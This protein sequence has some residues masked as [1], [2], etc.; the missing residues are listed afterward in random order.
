MSIPPCVAAALR[1]L[2][3]GWSPIVLWPADHAGINAENAVY[4][5]RQRADAQRV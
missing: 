5:R 3:R 2:E 4:D 1:Y